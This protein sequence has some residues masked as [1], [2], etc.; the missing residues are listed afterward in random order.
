M[1]M[2]RERLIAGIMSGTSADGVDVAL[3]ALDRASRPTLVHAAVH[4]FDAET[5]AA[6]LTLA[7]PDGGDARAVARLN[8][9]LARAYADA[10]AATLAES[11]VPIARLDLIGCHGQTIAHLPNEV[12]RSTLQAGSGPALAALSG[13]PVVYDFR[14]ADVALGGQGAPLIPFVDF[15]LFHERAAS[16]AVGVLNLGGIANLTLLPAGATDPAQVVAFDSGPANIVIDGLMRILAGADFDRAGR[17]AAAGNVHDGL[18]AELLRHGYFDRT[19]PKSTGR[20]EFGAPFV[21]ALIQRGKRLSLSDADLIATATMLTV[22]SIA[23]SL[24]TVSEQHRPAEL[25]LGGG[26]ALN[27]TLREMLGAELPDVTLLRHEDAGW[28]SDAK[29]AIGF[30]L[31]ADAAVRAVPSALPN[32]TGTREP[33]VL[34][35]LAPGRPPRIWPDWIGQS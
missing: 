18:L 33:L 19:P 11:A 4:P 26:G 10:L 2:P 30:A 9:H 13:V 28:P 27:A 23:R 22:R 32:V 15:L 20:E 25:I 3:V 12:V 8:F 17:L 14:A 16:H 6:I 24:E 29:E 7:E 34:G 21:A 1:P 35:A 5:H 31:L